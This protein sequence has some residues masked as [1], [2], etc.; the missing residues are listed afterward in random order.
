MPEQNDDKK[1]RIPL[2]KGLHRQLRIR[3][4]EFDTTQDFV[5]LEIHEREFSASGTRSRPPAGA[6][7]GREK[8][9]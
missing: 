7:W 5:V 9:R 2:V 6:P 8:D 3:W 4:A 1:I